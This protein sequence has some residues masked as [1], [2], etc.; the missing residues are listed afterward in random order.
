MYIDS[1]AHLDMKDF[2]RDRQ[3]VLERARSGGL[4]HIITIGIDYAS[5]LKGLELAKTHDFIFS[6]VG[7]HPH[8]ADEMNP[9]HLAALSRMVSEPKVVAWGEIGLDFYRNYAPRD[10][11]IDVFE[12]QLDM[13]LEVDLPVIIHDREA[14]D[15]VFDILKARG[16]GNRRGVIHCFSGDY[17]LAMVF[18]DL[19]YFISIPGVVTYKNA[20][21]THEVASRIPLESMLI[22]TDAPFLSPV[23]ERGKR[24]E[25][26]FVKYTAKEIARLRHLDVQDIAHQ[27]SENAIRLFNLPD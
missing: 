21:L 5:S 24:N 17:D 9:S 27:T 13:A 20:T 11:Q 8:D 15:Q 12:R 4:S 18:I 7:Y 22:E 14:H 26:L 6:T 16:K 10:R 1:H 23:P 3:Q 2:E 19:G 25:P